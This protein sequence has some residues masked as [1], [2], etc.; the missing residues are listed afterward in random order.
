MKISL[1]A[2]ALLLL[3]AASAPA[4][5]Q[6]STSLERGHEAAPFMI[7]MPSSATGELTLQICD[8]CQVL[9]LRASAATRYFIGEEQVTL[10]DIT[11]Y[12]TQNPVAPTV[13]VQQKDQPILRR[14][15]VSATAG[16][17]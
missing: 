1:L 10:A 12:F 8:T 4:L 14:V 11:A 3:G 15:T 16:R 2:A 6:M 7:R 13:V 17:K 5:A 9:R